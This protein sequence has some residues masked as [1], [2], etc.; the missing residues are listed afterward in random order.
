[1]VMLVPEAEAAKPVGAVNEGTGPP[2]P[3]PSP[4][5]AST[6]AAAAITA[7]ILKK[8]LFIVLLLAVKYTGLTK[9]DF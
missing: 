5:P 9:K 6:R 8:N 7:A 4:Q 2:P 3:A 1:M